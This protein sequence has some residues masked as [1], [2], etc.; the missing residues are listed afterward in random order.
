MTRDEAQLRAAVGQ[1][2]SSHR[3]H[4][5]PGLEIDDARIVKTGLAGGTETV[6][7]RL[8][9]RGERL[10]R[11]DATGQVVD[12]GTDEVSWQED[13]TLARDPAHSDTVE[14]QTFVRS[15][16]WFVAHRGWVVTAITPVSASP[17]AAPAELA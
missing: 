14:D 12:G 3:H 2:V 13:W 17:G 10:V 8:W 9:L 1:D 7:V 5:L 4:L 6:T 16:Q 11:D 15:G